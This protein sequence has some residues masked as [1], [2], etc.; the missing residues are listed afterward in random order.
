[1]ANSPQA[2]SPSRDR[3]H[4]A[5]EDARTPRT[6]AQLAASTGLTSTVV[7]HHLRTMERDGTAYATPETRTPGTRGRPA[8]TWAL[9]RRADPV[10]L[11]HVARELA[12]LAAADATEQARERSLARA[13]ASIAS[14]PDSG[15]D[16]LLTGLA[17]LGFSPRIT[18]EDAGRTCI[19][20]DACPFFDPA[21]GVTDT[22]ICRVHEL[23]AAGMLPPDRR[24][25]QLEIDRRGVG[26]RLHVV[27][28]S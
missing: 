2:Q 25:E 3:I 7:R 19:E 4:A 14:D 8:R 16:P 10:A 12:N 23:L 9:R 21:R 27:D 6:C 15:D 28:R 18:K 17:R 11:A 26:C 13:G 24:I 22:S 20:L 5:L 1:M